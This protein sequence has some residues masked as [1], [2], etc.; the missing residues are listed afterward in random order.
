M[1]KGKGPRKVSFHDYMDDDGKPQKDKAGLWTRDV[2]VFY[3]LQS[4][5][6]R[7]RNKDL[8]DDFGITAY[9]AGMRLK[10]L[11]QWGCLKQCGKIGNSREYEVTPWGKKMAQKWDSDGWEGRSS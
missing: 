4:N 5:K 8:Q 6:E 9:N 10:R 2:L 11:V 1:A 3:V 7:I